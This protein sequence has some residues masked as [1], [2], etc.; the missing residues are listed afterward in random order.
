M[1]AAVA[2]GRADFVPIY[3]H[4]VP[5]LVRS[6]VDV[7]LI[8]AGVGAGREEGQEAGRGGSARCL[9]AIAC[10]SSSALRS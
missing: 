8:Q 6:R 9:A 7:A 10:Q 4:E 1:R 5:A 2:D 3:L